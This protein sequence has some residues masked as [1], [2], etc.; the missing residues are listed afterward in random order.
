MF[1]ETE[2]LRETVLGIHD[3]FKSE[4]ERRIKQSSKK[5]VKRS[6]DNKGKELY[7]KI[8]NNT[9]KLIEQNK[10]LF[11]DSFNNLSNEFAKELNELKTLKTQLF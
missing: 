2:K 6:I 5:D 10:Q 9:D 8:S 1:N 4:I 3:D 7:E 11:T